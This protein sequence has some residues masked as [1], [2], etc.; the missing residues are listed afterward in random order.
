MSKLFGKNGG[1]GS[2]GVIHIVLGQ[3]CT[4]GSVS[5]LKKVFSSA[6][7]YGGKDTM[8]LQVQ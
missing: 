4:V 7:V 3:S 5:L 6:V 8:Y 1:R 2:A